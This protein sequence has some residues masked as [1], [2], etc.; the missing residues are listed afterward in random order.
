LQGEDDFGAGD[1]SGAWMNGLDWP[2]GGG[3]SAPVASA[4]GANAS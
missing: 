3:N 1:S 2:A 4:G